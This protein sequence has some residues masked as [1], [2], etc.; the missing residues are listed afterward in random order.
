MKKD[1][2]LDALKNAGVELEQDKLKE[3]VEAINVAN[4]LDVEKYKS[5]YN[6]LAGQLREVENK[7]N[8]LVE[9][10]K[11]FET[12]KAELEQ[13][14]AEKENNDL[15]QKITDAKIDERFSK[16]V[17]NEIKSGLKDGDKFEDNLAN[18]V[19]ENPQ[20]LTARQGAFK[21]SS[22]PDLEQGKVDEEK[23]SNQ[24]MNDLFR[25][26]KED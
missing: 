13:F 25:S 2:I 21:F 5:Q 23:T 1:V 19:K 10:T 7:Y 15:L 26:K 16:F 20:F 8:E 24:I 3:F 11:D 22:T 17:L 4:G 6:E 12:T 14:K 18:Y 9:A